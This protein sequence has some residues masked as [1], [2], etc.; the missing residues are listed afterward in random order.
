M[1]LK[2]V[3]AGPQGVGKSLI[4]N[5]LAGQTDK[6]VG[7]SSPTAGVR[8]LEFETKVRGVPETLEIELWDS[9]GDHR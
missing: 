2:I 9:S 6:L 8:I 7:D 3:V 5:F 1:R 4:S